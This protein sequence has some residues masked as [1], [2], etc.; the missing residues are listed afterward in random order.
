MVGVAFASGSGDYA[1]YLPKLNPLQ[2]MEAGQI[3]G[4]QQGKISFNTA[5]ADNLFVISTQPIVLGNEPEENKDHYEKAAFLGQVP[6][7]V[8]GPVQAGD[9]ILPSGNF[10]GFGIAIHQE[11]ASAADLANLVGIAWESQEEEDLVLSLIHI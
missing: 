11:K 4:I 2:E 1:E 5:D 10:D 6:V 3:V 8:Q 7:W 9:F